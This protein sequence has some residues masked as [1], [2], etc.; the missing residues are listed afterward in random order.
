MDYL[1]L[2]KRRKSEVF[3]GNYYYESSSAPAYFEYKI[4]SSPRAS[5]GDIINNLI[6]EGVNLVILTTWALKWKQN[7]KIV[8][9]NGETYTIKEMQ[10]E[11]HNNE[12]QRFFKNSPQSE[13]VLVLTRVETARKGGV[14]YDGRRI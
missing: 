7:A 5:F 12:N 9:Q 2:I 13:F 6:V 10:T 11:L 14:V 4:Q 8:L 1:D 3:A